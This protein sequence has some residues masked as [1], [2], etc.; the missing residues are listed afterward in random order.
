M[1]TGVFWLCSLLALVGE[2]VQAG[3]PEAGFNTLR[4]QIESLRQELEAVSSAYKERIETLEARL[5]RLEIR[6]PSPVPD[7]AVS[8]PSGPQSSSRGGERT[9]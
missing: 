5:A 4:Q 1:L 2:H 7:T 9:F 3:H 6:D 8:I